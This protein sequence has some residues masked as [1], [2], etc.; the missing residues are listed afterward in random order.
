MGV[1]FTHD[2]NGDGPY[3]AQQFATTSALFRSFDGC[4]SSST[5]A[6]SCSSF[7]GCAKPVLDCAYAGLGHALPSSW[8]ADTWSFFKGF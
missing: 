4:G 2:A 6:G 1:R 3:T 5:T 7:Q 8:A